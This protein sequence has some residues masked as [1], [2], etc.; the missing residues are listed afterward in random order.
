MIVLV[1]RHARAGDRN[2]WEGDDRVR[3]LDKKGRRHAKAL[4]A[5]LAGYP[6][7]RVLSSPYVRCVDSVAPLA[8]ARGLTVEETEALAEGATRDDVLRLLA[9]LDEPVV[10]LSTHGDVIYELL[11]DELRKGE[12]QVVALE[13]DELRQLER[14]ERPA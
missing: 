10:L 1:F 9:G 5:H 2:R 14:I 3:P 8:R 11:G 7:A 4:H 12:T 6:V 13:G